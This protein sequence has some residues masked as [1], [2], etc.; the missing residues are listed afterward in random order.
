MAGEK[1]AVLE[2]L[3]VE[4]QLSAGDEGKVD[5]KSVLLALAEDECNE[6]LVE[7]GPTLAGQFFQHNLWDEFVVY[8]A[9]KL[10]G[11]LARPLLVLPLDTMSQVESFEWHD[12][13]Q[14]GPDIR[15]TALNSQSVK[16]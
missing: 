15:M 8:V 1:K 3:G 12:V 9:P 2:E 11:N 14:I 7:A 10:M 6:V 4:V 16:P 5:L 13:V